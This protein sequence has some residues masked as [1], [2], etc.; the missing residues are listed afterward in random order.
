MHKLP[1]QNDP[2]RVCSEVENSSVKCFLNWSINL[3][4]MYSCLLY[5]H[6]NCLFQ[7]TSGLAGSSGLKQGKASS[8]FPP[9]SEHKNCLFKIT[10]GLAGSSGL[11]QGKSLISFPSPEWTYKLPVPNHQWI[12]R[13]LWLEAGEKPHLISLPWVNIK[14]ACSKSPVDWQ[15]ALAWSRG[16]PYLISL[17]WVNI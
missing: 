9:L 10:S 6:K 11:K 8:H 4:I 1:F 2:W 16:K 17:P 3:I 14:T 13:K 5:E 7:I 15:E 12:G